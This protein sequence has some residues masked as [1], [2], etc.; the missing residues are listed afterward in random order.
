[1]NRM[2]PPVYIALFANIV[3]FSLNYVLITSFGFIG[4]PLATLISR[5]FQLVAI[6]TFIHFDQ[7][8]LPSS[9]RLLPGMMT[10]SGILESCTKEGIIKFLKYEI[11]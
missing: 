3:N 1:M 7:K 11:D 6:V 9:D 4:A 2:K 5:C 10:V 8:S